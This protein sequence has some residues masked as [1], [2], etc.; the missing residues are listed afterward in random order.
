[1]GPGLRPRLPGAAGRGVGGG[2]SCSGG[3]LSPPRSTRPAGFFFAT[4]EE[5]PATTPLRSTGAASCPSGV[6]KRGDL[7]AGS[8]G[9][10][11]GRAGSTARGWE[12]S[13]P[14]EGVGA[15]LFVRGPRGRAVVGRWPQGQVFR[16]ERARN[17]DPA[18][19]LGRRRT[20][21]GDGPSNNGKSSPPGDA[22]RSR[23]LSL[24]EGR[25][26]WKRRGSGTVDMTPGQSAAT[27]RS[28]RWPYSDGRALRGTAPIRAV[29]CEEA[30][31]GTIEPCASSRGWKTPGGGTRGGRPV[32]V[33]RRD[34]RRVSSPAGVPVA[35]DPHQQAPLRIVFGGYGPFSGAKPERPATVQVGI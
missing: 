6:F 26:R 32:S 15:D 20:V 3:E 30:E 1:M 8:Y 34:A 25:T 29:P 21:I 17:W 9:L 10:L 23:K 18:G 7:Y 5:S 19:R 2:W 12:V 4:A 13:R 16:F 35:L 33:R 27:A 11:L 28:G 22:P 14:W 31:S 24:D